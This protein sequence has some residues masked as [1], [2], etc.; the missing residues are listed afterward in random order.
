MKAKHF[1]LLYTCPYTRTVDIHTLYT[2][3]MYIVYMYKCAQ[4]HEHSTN[5]HVHIHAHMYNVH[6][7]MLT[8][9]HLK[10]LASFSVPMSC[11]TAKNC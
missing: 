3:Y 9:P 10:A 1:P 2:T 5:I 4:K 11:T 8:L 6:I 7:H